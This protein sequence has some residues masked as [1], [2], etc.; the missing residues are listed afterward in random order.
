[1]KEGAK[2]Y[3]FSTSSP[4]F[5]KYIS[6][7]NYTCSGYFWDKPFGIEIHPG[8]YNQDCQQLSFP[9]ASFDVVISSETMEHIRKPFTGFKEIRRILKPGGSYFFTI[10]YREDRL[11]TS[12]VDT[13][14][15]DD[16]YTLPKTYHQDPYRKA[17]SLVYTDFGRDLPDLLR[18]VGFDTHLLYIDD[19]RLDIQDDLRPVKVF[20]A[21]AVDL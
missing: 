18:S 15:N 3:E 5:R 9:D 11:T 8:I 16:V 13:S 2:L 7:K 4:I 17:D 6:S 14:G 20:V 12:R 1:M 19:A 21:Q 10:P